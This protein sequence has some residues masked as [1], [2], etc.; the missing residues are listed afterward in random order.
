MG[1]FVIVMGVISMLLMKDSPEVKPYREGTY[2]QQLTS[3]FNFKKL[4]GN[5]NNKEMLLANVVVCTFFIPFNF[6]LRASFLYTYVKEEF[7][8]F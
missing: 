5:P 6:E 8:H 4:K 7:T 2:V 1:C 3:V